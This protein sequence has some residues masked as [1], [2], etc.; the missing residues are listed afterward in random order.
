MR[1]VSRF[2]KALPSDIESYT[3]SQLHAVFIGS[4]R[5]LADQ[6]CSCLQ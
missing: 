5:R 4:L 2:S 3:S 1:V 6:V